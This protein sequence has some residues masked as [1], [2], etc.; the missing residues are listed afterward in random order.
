MRPARRFVPALALITTACSSGGSPSAASHD[1]SAGALAAAGASSESAGRGGTSGLGGSASNAGDAASANSSSGA[2]NG[3]GGTSSAGSSAAGAPAGNSGASAVAGASPTA[4]AGNGGA[5]LIQNDVFWKDTAGNNL[6]SQGGGVL[7]VG[8]TYYWYGVNYA[9]AASYAANPTNQNS[10]TNFVAITVYSSTDLARWKFEG[11]ALTYASM[12]AKLTM[13]SSTWIG[14]VGAAYHAATKKYVIVGQYLGT[15][16]TQQFFATSDTPNGPFTVSGTQATIGN[17]VNGNCGDQAIFNDD[18]GQAYIVCSSLSGRANV[19]VVPLRA[20][21]FLAAESATR[22]YNGAGRE[23]NAMFKFNGR[24]YACSS[25][26]HGWN[27]SHTYCISATNILGPYST[28]SVMGNTDLDFS[29]VTQTGLFITVKGSSQSTV[30]FGGDRWSDF[31]G[32]GIGYNQW[33]PLT[34]D[35]VVPSMQSLSEWSLDASTGTWAVGPH[36][37]YALNPSFEA[38]RVATNPPAGWKTSAG[39]DVTTTHSGNFAWQLTDAAS[40]SQMRTALPNG[41]YTLT[42]WT[43]GTGKGTL[44]A[45]SFGGTDLSTALAGSA[46]AWS[47]IKLSGIAVSNGQCQI[48]AES[49]TGSLSVDDFTL[50]KD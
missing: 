4:G 27:A 38:D 32:N 33:L 3:A 45:K 5:A 30:I 47:Q 7:A 21:D 41:S 12:A 50:T 37:N 39:A 10:N 48:G 29:H 8:S 22:I 2:P 40:V 6:Y 19:Y 44:Q 1:G 17:V 9:G 46:S 28:E 24:Y 11:N 15:P 13:S 25:D 20:A 43:R 35:G 49:S 36:N 42:V 23:G 31:A 34:F 14:R 26:L 18:D 16:D